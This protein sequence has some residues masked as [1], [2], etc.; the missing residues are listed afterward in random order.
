M[1]YELSLKLREKEMN[2]PETNI[3]LIVTFSFIRLIEIG[4]L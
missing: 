4:C 3:D 2:V 1:Q